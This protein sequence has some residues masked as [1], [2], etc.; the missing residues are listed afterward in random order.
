MTKGG[1]DGA[2]GGR[3]NEDQRQRQMIPMAMGDG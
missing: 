2:F 1:S 3:V